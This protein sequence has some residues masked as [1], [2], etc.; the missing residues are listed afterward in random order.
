MSLNE[1]ELNE[2][3]EERNRVVQQQR[4]L[5]QLSAAVCA[6]QELD[7]VF[8]VVRDA[9]YE[10]G[11]VDRVGLFYD[12]GEH[13]RGTWGTDASGQ[14]R[15]EHELRVDREHFTLPFPDLTQGIVPYLIQ[16]LP[17]A[18]AMPSGEVRTNVPSAVFSLFAGGE[19]QGVLCVDTLLT[20]RPI[21]REMLEPLLPFMQQCAVAIQNAKLFS[22]VQKEL[23]ERQK[24]EFALREQTLELVATRDQALAATRA[25][26]EFLANMSHEIRTPMNGVIGMAELLLNTELTNP[27]RE[28]VNIISRSADSLLRVINDVL[29]FSKIEA[30]KLSIESVDFNLRSLIEVVAEMFSPHAHEKRL[31]FVCDLSSSM[32]EHL[33]GDPTRLQQILANFVTNAVKFTSEGDV[34]IKASVLKESKRHALLRI[35]VIDTGIGI[36]PEMHA[37]IF[38]SFTQA[39][40]STTRRFGGT[41]L[42]LTICRQLAEMMGGRVGL[43][44]VLGTGSTFWVEL[45]FRKQAKVQPSFAIPVD[46]SGSRVLIVDDNATN[47]KILREQLACWEC[48]T[49]EA[50]GGEEA[51]ELLRQKDSRFDT[52]IL[53]FQMPGMDGEELAR[54]IRA[55]APHQNTPLILLSSVC[56]DVHSAGAEFDAVLTKPV[57]QSHLLETLQK[58]RMPETGDFPV[59]VEQPKAKPRLNAA[60]LR[61][62]VAED[63]EVNQKVIS[64]HLARWDCKP[65]LVSN[66]RDALA[67][68]ESGD[69]DLVLMDVQMPGMDGFEATGRH[70]VR[71]RKTGGH[72]PIV[73]ITAHAMEGDR[74]RCL[75]AGMDDYLT[76]PIKSDE[77]E[78]MIVK[79]TSTSAAKAA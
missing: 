42:G 39:D 48:V 44:S 2:L 76:K 61:V 57:K 31:E 58:V 52:M 49:L 64:H 23:E 30:G 79:W 77:L 8:K 14:L 38:E 46:L 56:P 20:M 65:V 13:F 74:E 54:E 7:D 21:T 73:A 69:F 3:L 4:R 36:S 71:E 33:V 35:E 75:N 5:M 47:R 18:E 6:N 1:K 40:G 24:A 19:L 41:G 27:Q 10:A 72:V 51:L 43:E 16:V 60:G 9:I 66:G 70:R 22:R 12:D 67:T 17:D 28:Y 78:A 50:K 63:N 62:L 26:S 55:I 37:A 11:G 25:K 34:A 53:D 68:L 15:D 29:D 45:G 59:I 32:P